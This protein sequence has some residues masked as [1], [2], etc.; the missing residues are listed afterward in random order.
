MD[1]VFEPVCHNISIHIKELLVGSHGVDRVDVFERG[2]LSVHSCLLSEEMRSRQ[3]K[4]NSRLC[5]QQQL[6]LTLK[7]IWY[8]NSKRLITILYRIHS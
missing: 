1:V 7:E 6:S 8:I 5:Y 2:I 4:W 3:G